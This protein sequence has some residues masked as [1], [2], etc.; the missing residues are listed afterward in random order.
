LGGADAVAH[1]FLEDDGQ[2][3]CDGVGDGGCAAAVVSGGVVTARNKLT[4][5]ALR[6]PK[7]SGRARG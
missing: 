1:A 7:S 4:G 6:S 5:K 3:V 2:E